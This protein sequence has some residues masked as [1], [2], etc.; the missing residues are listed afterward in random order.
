MKTPNLTRLTRRTRVG[1]ACATASTAMLFASCSVAPNGPAG[2][3]GSHG[4]LGSSNMSDYFYHTAAGWTYTFKNVENIY[5]S[6]G[7][8]SQTLTGA[9]DT[10]RTL[11]FDQ[12][13]P[14]GDSLF[15]YMI[16]YRVTS[17]YAG[18]PWVYINYLQSTK[19]NKTHGAFVNV[20][21]S[22]QGMITMDKKKPI[23]TDTILAGIAGLMR[24]RYDDFTN[25]SSY[26]WQTDTIWYSEHSDSAFLWEHQ[27]QTGP[28][29]MERCIFVRSFHNNETWD[30]DVINEPNPTTT[31]TVANADLSK[32]VPAGT[33]SHT[34]EIQIKT[35]AIED[36]DFNREYK[37]YGAGVGPIFQYDWWYSTSDG[38]TFTKQ[39]FTR[40]LI[41]LTHN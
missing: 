38:N 23:S 35:G 33:W 21:D 28:I 27:N 25:S 34:A 13:G 16:T 8:I 40:S 9:N 39:D 2:P 11:G 32:T 1:I 6:D 4:S 24:T 17:A 22:V 36:F 37:Y 31:C 18:G 19:S 12:I 29:V 5:N 30:Y 41:S 7:S 20:G 15:R 10:V 3:G 14:N 26:V